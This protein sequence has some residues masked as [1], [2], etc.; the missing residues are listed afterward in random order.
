VTVGIEGER[1]E[2]IA[3]DDVHRERRLE[4]R[5]AGVE[6]LLRAIGLHD[7]PLDAGRC[8]DAVCQLEAEVDDRQGA[9]RRAFGGDEREAVLAR[10]DLRVDGHIGCVDCHVARCVSDLVGVRDLR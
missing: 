8:R 10:G 7:R 9:D 5:G 6:E 4:R 3:A 1:G 2:A